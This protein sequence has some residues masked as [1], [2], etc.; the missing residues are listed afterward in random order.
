MALFRRR[1]LQTCGA[2]CLTAKRMCAH[3]SRWEPYPLTSGSSIRGTSS[4]FVDFGHAKHA[5]TQLLHNTNQTVLAASISP[6]RTNRQLVV[7]C[8]TTPWT[9]SS[10]PYN[11]DVI[12]ECF[13]TRVC[14]ILPACP[15]VVMFLTSAHGS[16]FLLSR[17]VDTLPVSE[18]FS[19]HPCEV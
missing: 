5:L 9:D 8:E 3:S 12:A 1:P 6:L 4:L 17:L 16:T 11:L 18:R 7:L 15:L 14:R 19:L 2:R 10:A 13:N